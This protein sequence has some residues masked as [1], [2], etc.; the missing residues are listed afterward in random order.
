MITLASILKKFEE[1][2]AAAAFAEAGEHE[3]ARN[4]T[5][6]GKNAH[7]KVLLGVEE[8][9]LNPTTVRSALNICSRMGAKLEIL[10]IFK[11][12]S[13][14]QEDLNGQEG[15]LANFK[16][17]MQKLGIAYQ[18]VLAEGNESEEIFRFVEKR[19]DIVCVVLGDDNAPKNTRPKSPLLEKL[20]KLHC[21]VVM[22][23][24]AA[25]A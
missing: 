18:L 4:F 22:C 2:M 7:K 17:S 21:P 15:V 12:A 23:S 14:E 16:E 1:A 9:D 6:S 3:T 19:R 11:K 25:Q 5:A 10:H 20:K 13:A 24:T 8:N